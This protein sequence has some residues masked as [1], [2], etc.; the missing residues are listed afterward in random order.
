MTGAGLSPGPQADVSLPVRFSPAAVA[1][2]VCTAATATVAWRILTFAGFNNDHNIYLAGAQQMVLGEWPVHD[3]VDPGWP[4]MYAVSAT[5]RFLFGRALLVELL[6]VAFALAIGAAFTVL[7]ARRLSGSIVIALAVTLLEVVINP[8]SFGYP[9]ILLFAV[10]G[11]AFIRFAARPTSRGAVLLGALTASAFLFRHDHGLYIGAGALVVV[12][13]ASWR[14]GARSVTSRVAALAVT[15]VVLLLPWALFGT[16]LG[17]FVRVLPHRDRIFARRSR[18]NGAPSV[19]ADG[20][21]ATVVQGELVGVAVLSVPHA[22]GRECDVGLWA[23]TAISG[24]VDGRIGRCRRGG[25]HGN[26]H[27]L[28]LPSPSLGGPSS[29]RSRACG[30]IGIMADR[31]DRDH[32]RPRH[33]SRCLRRLDICVRD[34]SG[35]GRIDGGRTG[36]AQ[37]RWRD[38]SPGRDSRTNRRFDEATP[39]DCAGARSASQ[40]LFHRAHALLRVSPALFGSRRPALDDRSLPRCLR[41]GES[42]LCGRSDVVQARVLFFTTRPDTR[43]RTNALPVG[44]VRRFRSRTGT[45]IPSGVGAHRGSRRGTL[46]H[47]RRYSSP[48][49]GRPAASGRRRSEAVRARSLHGLALFLV[50]ECEYSS[51][52]LLI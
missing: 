8:R 40:P 22:A 18:G 33:A 34:D 7:A 46:Q 27:E 19:P 23:G 31:I 49:N 28:C 50:V 9:K 51:Q 41:D 47:D 3:F 20:R 43:S 37:S 10:A 26:C 24:A 17:R 4:L 13:L 48:R 15:A 14:A 25:R 52:G 16:V 39:K 29:R 36:R 30:S 2:A 21:R 12:V 35:V 32:N 44:A 1:I 38:Q 11:W 6:V 5:A 42:R 45:G